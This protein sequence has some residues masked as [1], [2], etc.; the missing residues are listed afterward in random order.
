MATSLPTVVSW[1]A[2]A[3]ATSTTLIDGGVAYS[4][5]A[6]VAGLLSG[7]DGET[8]TIE[9]RLVQHD[10]IEVGEG[11]LVQ[12]MR[13]AAEVVLEDQRFTIEAVAD[14]RDALGELLVLAR[15]RSDY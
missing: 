9:L 4:R 8:T 11:G 5:S 10:D 6:I 2:P 3:W 7:R 14:L 1:R 13:A 12:V 15:G